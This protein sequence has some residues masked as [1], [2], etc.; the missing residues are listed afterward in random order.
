VAGRKERVELNL[1]VNISL[2]VEHER[3]LEEMLLTGD[4]DALSS[5]LIPKSH[6]QG[7][8]EFRRLFDSPRQTEI[9]YFRRTGIF[10][11][12]HMVVVRQDI[13]DAHPWVV[14]RL[15]NAF[16]EAK[17]VCFERI[18]GYGMLPAVLPTFQHDYEET[19]RVFGKDFW[20]YGVASNRAVLGA[21]ARYSHEQGLSK[22]L[23]EVEELFAPTTLWSTVV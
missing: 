5:P 22:R 8:T 6:L 13:H 14:K 3:T 12:M 1:P 18:S 16:V 20:P 9:D 15:M 21:A 2:V 4:I 17:R 23:V 11:I 10:P 7:R 19:I